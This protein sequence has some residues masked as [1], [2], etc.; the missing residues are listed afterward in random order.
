MSASCFSRGAAYMAA[1]NAS[2]SSSASA[3]GRSDHA[4]SATP[5]RM[6]EQRAEL[7]HEFRLAELVDGLHPSLI[8]PVSVRRDRWYFRATMSATTQPPPE[9][10]LARRF[11]FAERGTNTRTEVLEA[12]VRRS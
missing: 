3:N 1:R 8:E 11:R 10:G 6:L 9:G 2:N 12:A 5:G 7:A 4:P